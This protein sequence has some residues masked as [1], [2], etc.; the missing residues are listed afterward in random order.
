MRVLLTGGSGFIG[1]RLAKRLCEA[2][3]LYCV[4]R[5]T[6][7]PLPSGTIPVAADLAAE[8]PPDC[9]PAR[10]DAVLHLAQSPDYRSFPE[11]AGS[12]FAINTAATAALLE[13]ALAAGASHFVLAST[14]TIYEPYVGRLAEDASVAPTSYYSATKLAAEALIRGWQ[15]RFPACALR[16][17]F[18]YGPGQTGRLIS[19]LVERIRSGLAVTLDGC[20]DGLILTPTFVDDIAAV[21]EA[22]LNAAWNGVFNVAAPHPVGL[23]QLADQIGHVIGKEPRFAR[24][25]AS[26]APHI[27]PELGRLAERF[28]LQRFRP[29]PAGLMETVA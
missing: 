23:R 15:G 7:V 17:F 16:L 12:M 25:G 11:R 10:I 13:Y 6:G 8:F 14:G 29:L 19:E 20:G 22:A 24:S 9:L 3:E 21:F 27:V 26:V 18:P 5:Q 1:T 28:D 4:V 2:H